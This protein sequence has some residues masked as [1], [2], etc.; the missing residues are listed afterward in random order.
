MG[1]GDVKLAGVVGLYLGYLGWGSLAVGGFAAFVLGGIFSII[2]L[3][4][5]RGKGKTKIPFGP[6]MLL[7]A[8]VGILFG[9]PIASWYLE[10]IGLGGL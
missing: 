7:G 2:L 5:R 1:F 10:L 4:S 3:V 8:W 6:W 9:E